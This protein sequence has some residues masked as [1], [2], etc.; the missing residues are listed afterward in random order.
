[1]LDRATIERLSQSPEK[2]APMLNVALAEEGGAGVLLALA[3]SHAVGPEAVEVIGARIEAEGADVGRDREAKADEHFVSLAPELDRLLVAHPN[4]SGRVLDGILSRH[5][6]DA[7]FVLAA[8]C[9]PRATLSAVELAVDWPAAS[10][11]HDRLWLAV[12]DPAS[13]PPLTLAE[14]A[15]DEAPRRREAAAR[16]GRDKAMLAAL[17]RDPSRQVRRAVASNRYAAEERARLAAE[18]PAPEVRARAAGGQSA[19]GE[20]P[21]EGAS[22]VDTARFAAG[23]RAMGTGGV[24]A[25]DVARALGSSAEKLDEEGAMLAAL[26]LPRKD[27]GALLDQALDL[28]LGSPIVVSLAAGFALRPP[29]PLG[30]PAGLSDGDETELTEVVY[31][32]VK[33]LARMTTS[34]SRLTGKARLAAWAAE[35]LLRSSAVDRE[36]LLFDLERSPI[37]ADRMVLA[38][39]SAMRPS[40]VRELCAAAAGR[41]VTVPA[42]LI[43]LAWVDAGV[44]DE[45]LVDLAGR[46]AKAKKRAEELPEDEMDLDPSRRS[47]EVL[48]RVVL[49]ATSRVSMSPRAALTVVALDARRVRYILSAMPQWK[50][51]L[52][53]VRLARV[54]RQHAGALSAAHA[55]ARARG[56]KIEGWTER[57]MS[58]LEVSVA[59]AVG[60]ITGAEVARR[61][62]SG[63]QA[64]TDGVSL[65]GAAEVR[66][67]M[68][69]PEAIAGIL[70]WASKIRTSNPNAFALWLLL[71]K[72]DRERAPTL[73]ASSIDGIATA[74][75]V[76]TSG[77]VEA[78]A[79]MERRVP[80]RLESVHPQSPRG[81]ATLASAIA[82]AYRALGGLS[83][84][85]QGP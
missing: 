73:I 42:A 84:E 30:S 48:E 59:L 28:G 71:E 2:N 23:L 7:F 10:P 39:G 41:A 58:E 54:L 75:G 1:M 19:H 78:L 35:G 31:D 51:R 21:A 55:Q 34:E 8:A 81:R 56:S 9:H 18:D 53:G 61:L 64:L 16:I 65:A 49:A 17:A 25:P 40:L 46:V 74:Q 80:G 50:G 77:V 72:F 70:Q 52:S 67:A 22:I 66:A 13:V 47:L 36:R 69:G 60:H 68:E 38:R 83:H 12:I 32:A 15:Q 63:R 82:K 37:A 57:M 11:V 4:A 79:V 26:V 20:Q 76:V 24:L 33:S 29:S 45:V 44:S 62:A 14:W 85:R 27:L 6:D 3:R 43:E 5:Q